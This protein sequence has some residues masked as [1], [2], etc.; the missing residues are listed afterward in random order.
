MHYV[1]TFLEQYD[2][3]NLLSCVKWS[4]DFCSKFMLVENKISREEREDCTVDFFFFG[5]GF[6]C[7]FVVVV[8]ESIA[9]KLF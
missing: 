8:F 7:C 2:L 9:Q 6:C 5:V 1:K 4:L 3:S